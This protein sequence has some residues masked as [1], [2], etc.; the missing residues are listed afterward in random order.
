M[1]TTGDIFDALG[2]D[3]VARYRDI[4]GETEGQ[5]DLG[6][7]ELNVDPTSSADFDK[8]STTRTTPR[9][10][11]SLVE[12]QVTWIGGYTHVLGWLDCVEA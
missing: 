12:I 1:Y 9:Q 5:V 3:V 4:G 7:I 6:D 8:S 2:A 11:V 10:V